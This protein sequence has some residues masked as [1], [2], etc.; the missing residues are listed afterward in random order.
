MSA[1]LELSMGLRSYSEALVLVG[2][3]VPYLLL[4]DRRA[5]DSDFE[6]VG[7]IDIDL[8]VDPER[9]SA[10]E[11][12]TIVE[13][14]SDMGWVSVENRDF[15]YSRAVVSPEDSTPYVITVDFMAPDPMRLTRRARHR[16]VQPDLKAR[17]MRGASL[18]LAHQCLTPVEAKLPNGG[19]ARAEIRMADVVGCIATKGLALGARMVEKDAYDVFA[20]LDNIEGGPVG[21][22]SAFMP[23]LGDPLVRE[24]LDN[25]KG[26]FRG[27]DSPGA[28]LVAGFYATEKGLARDRMATRASSVVSAFTDALG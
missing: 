7:S 2:G 15:S 23:F 13:M 5:S 14:I 8:V 3:W 6:H 12:S 22:A 28:L 19:E 24:S 11:Y 4:R 25:I 9:M 1:L 27:S 26:M 18:A 16:R 17:T 10:D 20:V 21:V